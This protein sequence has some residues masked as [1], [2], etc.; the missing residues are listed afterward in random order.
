MKSE[1]ES[2]RKRSALKAAIPTTEFE[3]F[4]ISGP[5]SAAALPK[6]D[7]IS[8][9]QLLGVQFPFLLLCGRSPRLI[10]GHPRC[11]GALFDPHRR[12]F[13]GRARPFP[14]QPSALC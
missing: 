12:D 2:P 11:E 13:C 7:A 4:S 14:A 6:V 5:Y 1:F 8:G 3:A 9:F 10:G